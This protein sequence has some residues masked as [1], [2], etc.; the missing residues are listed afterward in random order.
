MPTGGQ[1]A[2]G[3]GTLFALDVRAQPS[4]KRDC[5]EGLVRNRLEDGDRYI[6][7]GEFGEEILK[8]WNIIKE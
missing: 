4:T 2:P 5:L 8:A 6:W 7:L 3:C 1:N